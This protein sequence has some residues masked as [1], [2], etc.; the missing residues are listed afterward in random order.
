MAWELITIAYGAVLLLGSF[1]F[2]ERTDE[3]Y[4]FWGYLLGSLAAFIGLTALDKGGVGYLAYAGLGLGS[5][6]VSVLLARKVFAFAGAA[7]V[8]T[9]LGHLSF[10][11]FA[12]SALFPLV[13]TG[14]GCATIYGGVLYHRHSASIDAAILRLVPEI[15]RK[16]LPR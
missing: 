10:I 16:R 12:N 2:D 11:V 8:L 1:A 9:Y 7:A 15:L 14:I 6:L 5:M 13:L 4:S 3:D